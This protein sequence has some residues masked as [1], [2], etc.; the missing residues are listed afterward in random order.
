MLGPEKNTASHLEGID[1]FV[2]AFLDY[3]LVNRG[4][5]KLTVESYSSDLTDFTMFLKSR[6]IVF[7][8]QIEKEHV[9]IFLD[10]LNQQGLSARNKGK[11]A[12][13]SKRVFQITY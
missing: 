11:E 5:A 10:L 1:I 4:L 9:L 7:P 6:N 3:T 2:N 8:N 13:V 12:I